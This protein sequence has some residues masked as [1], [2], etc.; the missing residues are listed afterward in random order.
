MS[1]PFSVHPSIRL[2]VRSSVCRQDNN[3]VCSNRHVV[4]KISICT[5]TSFPFHSHVQ[6][7]NVCKAN[8]RSFL[9]RCSCCAALEIP[10][11]CGLLVIVV[12]LKLHF[13]LSRNG[14]VISIL[15]QSFN[16]LCRWRVPFFWMNYTILRIMRLPVLF[17]GFNPIPWNSE[18]VYYK[19][20]SISL[21]LRTDDENSGGNSCCQLC[22][23]Y[24]YRNILDVT[25][26]KNAHAQF[27]H[28]DVC[29]CFKGELW[30]WCH[31]RS[32]W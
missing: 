31:W 23:N 16:I 19:L 2:F 27:I 12:I 22:G 4:E 32:S 6:A 17:Y 7:E 11:I 24:N 29:N 28:S 9:A 14:Y 25:I 15:A 5:F 26:H 8:G 30:Q 21:L 13:Q 20:I 3:I 10:R 1:F 18:R